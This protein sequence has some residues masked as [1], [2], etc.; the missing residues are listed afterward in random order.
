[1]LEFTISETFDHWED[2]IYKTPE[3]TGQSFGI[4]NSHCKTRLDN[5][6]GTL[7]MYDGISIMHDY[8][9]A[10][11]NIDIRDALFSQGREF[12]GFRKRFKNK[13]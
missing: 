6:G 7:Y 3:L 13:Y 8:N 12:Y 11:T 9:Y 5:T 1:M 4:N 10:N 2:I